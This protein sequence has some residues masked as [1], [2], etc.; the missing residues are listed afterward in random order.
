MT[1]RVIQ[2]GTGNVGTH[3]LRYIIESPD[4]ELAGVKVDNEA[5]NGAD[6]G[7]L[8]GVPP[9]GV[10][11]TTDLD[12]LLSI[13]ADCVAYTPLG[14]AKGSIDDAV[15]DICMLL[16]RGYNVVSSAVECAIYPRA[17]PADV[18]RRLEKAC[19]VGET[20]ICCTGMTPGFATDLWP[21]TVSRV[22]RRVDSLRVTE[23]VNFREYDSTMMP[24]MGFGLHPDAPCVMHDFFKAD[25]ANSVYMAPM[26]FIADAMGVHIDEVTYNRQVVVAPGRV[27]VP[28]GTFEAGTIVGIRFQIVAWV[29]AREFFTL[30]FVW[31]ADDGIAPDWPAGHCA[32]ELEIDGDPCIRTTMELT[33]KTDAKRPTSLTVAMKCLNAVPAVVAAQPGIVNHLGMPALAGRASAALGS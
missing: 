28:S 3:A 30:D 31:R 20:T 18:L 25:P 21:V 15:S 8:V 14:M 32:W 7:M 24:V 5:K 29:A 33:T 9:T 2:W 13:D 6:A 27:T 16:K 11:A 17:L 23:I 1:Y 10:T 22:G 26:H 12:E 4:L 19:E